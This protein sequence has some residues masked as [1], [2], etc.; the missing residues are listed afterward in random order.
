MIPAFDELGLLPPGIHW[1]AI[2]EVRNRYALNLHRRRLMEGFEKAL[3]ALKA[4]GC[5]RI[6]SMAVL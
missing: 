1:A 3:A 4:A 5:Q 2:D 6:F